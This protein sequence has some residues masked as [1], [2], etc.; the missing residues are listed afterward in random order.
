MTP[1][2]LS[3]VY[4]ALN[5]ELLVLIAKA[6]QRSTSKSQSNVIAILLYVLDNFFVEV[7]YYSENSK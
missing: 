5:Q 7:S 2:G 1:S 3:G 6:G 4:H